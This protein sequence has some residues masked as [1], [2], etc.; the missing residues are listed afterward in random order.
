[1]HGRKLLHVRECAHDS[2]S[3]VGDCRSGGD[4]RLVGSF[5]RS[6]SALGWIGGSEERFGEGSTAAEFAHTTSN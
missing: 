6:L 1:M 5:E 4:P 3:S 2:T